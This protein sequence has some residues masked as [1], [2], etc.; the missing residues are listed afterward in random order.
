MSVETMVF[1]PAV[2]ILVLLTQAVVHCVT[3]AKYV[4]LGINEFKEELDAYTRSTPRYRIV[5]REPAESVIGSS[6]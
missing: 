6:A 4:M 1:I 5:P 3:A 2:N